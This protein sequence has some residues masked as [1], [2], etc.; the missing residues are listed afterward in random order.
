MLLR[1]LERVSILMVFAM[2]A[3]NTML[4]FSRGVS[5]AQ[6]LIIAAIIIAAMA[7]ITGLFFRTLK[8]DETL[9]LLFLNT[10]ILFLF[11]FSSVLYS[12]LLL[13]FGRPPIDA[14]LVEIDAMIG[15][16]WPAIMTWAAQ[17]PIVSTVTRTAYEASS[18]LVFATFIVVALHRDYTRV[19]SFMLAIFISAFATISI[20]AL[21]PSAGA[22]A[23]WTLPNDVEQS[24]NPLV[25]TQYGQQLLIW[26]ETG[27]GDITTLHKNG[28]VG[29]PSYHT[30]MT[31][32]CIYGLWGYWKSMVVASP[33]IAMTVPAIFIQGGHN[34]MDF[35]AGALI[36]A[37]AV[38]AAQHIVRFV[39]RPVADQ[40]ANPISVTPEASV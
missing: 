21:L 17:Y 13:P 23:Y 16:H 19:Y 36:T 31:L 38:Y 15:F 27:F 20:W 18:W 8:K 6:P 4:A 12:H 29:F 40:S 11:S 1:P 7:L 35:I 32:I 34:L 39:N 9:S 2:I 14:T 37:A 30:V 24:I 5:V 10:G 33:V 26:Y 22:S 3:I 28:L 25:G